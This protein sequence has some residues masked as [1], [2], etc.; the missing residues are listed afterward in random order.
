M[1]KLFLS[2][3]DINL[4]FSAPYRK[5]FLFC[6]IFHLIAAFFSEG[7]LQYD[8]HFE[9]LEFLSFKLGITPKNDLTMEYGITMRPWIQPFVYY[10]I[11]KTSQFFGIENRFIW[12]F[13]LRL[14]SSLIGFVSLVYFSDY[15]LKIIKKDFLKKAAVAL[16]CTLWF[17]PFIHARISCEAVA[18]SIFMIAFSLLMRKVRDSKGFKLTIPHSLIIGILFGLSFTIRYHIGLMI[19]FFF[20]WLLIFK[21]LKISELFFLSLGVLLMI[22][23]SV[24]IDYWG[25][26]KWTF[27]PYHYYHQN[28]VLKLANKW[29]TS[30]WWGYF[31][32]SMKKGTPLIALPIII[33]TVIFWIKKWKHELTWV[34]L[35]FFFVH[36]YIAHKELRFLFPVLIYL[37]I[38]MIILLDGSAKYF[39]FFQKIKNKR[40]FKYFF[41]FIVVFNLLLLIQ[42]SF[43]S[44]QSSISFYKWTYYNKEKLQEKLHVFG[45]LRPYG[46]AALNMHYYN[47]HYPKYEYVDES[48]M[49]EIVLSKTKG[50]P[51]QFFSSKGKHYFAMSEI[52]NCRNLYLSVPKI[53]L[54]FNIGNWINRSEVWSL[55]ECS[56]D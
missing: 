26:D 28:I 44:L 51:K 49:K 33:S 22:G 8:E 6:A 42:V 24:V 54:H 9:I 10:P 41:N 52:S 15:L 29:G 25:Y 27:A 47:F 5:L 48:N 23:L 4:L 20:L 3:A 55:F 34:T 40:L 12:A 37:P 14:L 17:I 13:I 53:V 36:S 50:G 2:R 38:L 39:Y 56:N 7:F 11:I 1:N 43:R 19:L 32:S 21:K 30:P 18:G 45:D 46:I 31:I 35:P 16:L